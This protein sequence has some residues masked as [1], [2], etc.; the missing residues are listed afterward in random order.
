MCRD[1]S[2]FPAL[3]SATALHNPDGTFLMSRSTVFN[4]RERKQ[5]EY[6]LIASEEKFRLLFEHMQEGFALHELI[7][8]ING[9]A[10]DFRFLAVNRAYERH[11]GLS[12]EQV[13]GRTMLEVTPNSSREQIAAY[14]RVALTGEPLEFEHFSQAFQR[15]LHIHAFSPQSGRLATI[16]EDVT[17]RVRAEQA[18]RQSEAELRLSRDRLSAANAALEKAARMKDEFLAS[19]SHEL[20][21]PLTGILGLSEA[22]QIKTYGDLSERQLNAVKNIESSGQH[23]LTLINDI[24]DLSK[25]EAGMFQLQ[26][27]QISV[28][29]ICRASLQLTRGMA[30]KKRQ[31]VSFS[32][33]HEHLAIQADPRRLKQMLVNLL[34]NAVKFTPQGGRLGLEVSASREEEL[35]RLAVWDQGI[36]IAPED[37]TRLFQ[38]FVQ[39]D[40]SLE[41]EYAG[42]GLGLA[43]VQRMVELHGGGIEVESTPGQGSRFTILLPW[44]EPPG[45]AAEAPA[46]A[47]QPLPLPPEDPFEGLDPRELEQSLQTLGI[48]PVFQ[49]R[50]S[51]A[52]ET[53]ARLKPEVILLDLR[54]PGLPAP[55]LLAALR[56]DPHTRRIPVLACAPEP[57]RLPAQE[58]GADGFLPWPCSLETLRREFSRVV[59][60][61]QLPAAALV[62]ARR[63]PLPAVLLVDDNETLLDTLSDVLSRH[64]LQVTCARSGGEALELAPRLLPDVILMDIQMPGMNGMDAIRRLRLHADPQV[65]AIPIIAL[66]ALAMNGDRERC[67]QAGASG[68]LAK[69]ARLP[70]LLHLIHQ[71]SQE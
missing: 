6:A 35:V 34:S 32:I 1:G 18:L 60:G 21:T 63:H 39:L 7:R 25:L 29:D 54:L 28:N 9:Q 55:E 52:V 66:T 68:Y 67:L 31:Q 27:E 16:F 10:V 58:L 44:C 15:H 61:Q 53:A 56:A 69:P 24:L 62:V 46:R 64:H 43:L 65:A 38:P 51:Q 12:P 33:Q 57:Q 3:V 5:A 37:Q 22:L 50:W 45:P 17:E 36:G 23:L 47:P 49:P 42:S 2:T 41:R 14:A 70:D 11:T 8:G 20:R 40:G 19:M 26:L 71:F 13:L 4:I 48:R 59:P 30:H